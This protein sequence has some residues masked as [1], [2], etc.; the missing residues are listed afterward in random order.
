MALRSLYHSDPRTRYRLVRH[1]QL[2]R[3]AVLPLR[4][5]NSEPCVD[6]TRMGSA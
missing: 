3:M 5:K 2:G 6:V 4:L 1:R